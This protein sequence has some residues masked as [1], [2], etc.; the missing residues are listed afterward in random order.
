MFS[1]GYDVILPQKY[2]L[3]KNYAK[4]KS[5]APLV[6]EVIT[7]IESVCTA[8]FH[9]NGSFSHGYDVIMA[10]QY[11]FDQNMIKEEVWRH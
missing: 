4:T 7:I 5:L 11:F 9:R 6:A 8:D 10:K 2:F 3:G 1:H